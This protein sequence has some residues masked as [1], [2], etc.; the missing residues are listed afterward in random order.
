MDR[1]ALTKF[2]WLSIG[3]A[4]VTIVLKASA[5]YI[6]GSVGLLSDALESVVNLAAA[7]MALAMLAVAAR[8]PDEMHA[9]G[10]SKAEYFSS[11]F[12]GALILLAAASILWTALPRLIAPRPLEQVG[13]G[14]AVSAVAASVNYA[15]ARLLL[16]AAEKYRS[17]TLEADARH[18]LTDVWTSA[19]VV[20]GVAVVSLTGLN[21]VDPIIAIVVAVNILW[22]GVKLL[23]RSVLGLLDTTLPVREQRLIKQILSGYER[24]GIHYHALRTRYAGSRSFISFHVLVPGDWTVQRGHDLLEEVERKIRAAIPGATVFTHLEPV[25]DP[26]AWQDTSL[27]RL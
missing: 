11:G 16:N 25:G 20:V 13:T 26:A 1:V 21:R 7:L 18:L 9:Y 14:L 2:G 8:P 10:Y 6:T 19:G 3:A 22:T 17:I 15:V 24:D 27:D 23:Q 5:Y 12:E 4:V